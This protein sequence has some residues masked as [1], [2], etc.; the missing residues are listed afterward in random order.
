LNETVDIVNIFM[1]SKNKKIAYFFLWFLK[2]IFPLDIFFIYISNVFPFPGLPFRN[3][4]SHPSSLCLYEGAP[5]PP[6]I[7]L[8]W[9][10]PTLGY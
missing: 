2:N 1:E 8:P 9:H 3:P 5:P 4:L 10:S 6:P 7:L